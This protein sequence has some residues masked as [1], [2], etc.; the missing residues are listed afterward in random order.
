MKP[1]NPNGVNLTLLKFIGFFTGSVIL[2]VIIAISF[3]SPLSSMSTPEFKKPVTRNVPDVHIAELN[4]VLMTD[5]LLHAKWMQLEEV[6]LT[7]AISISDSSAILSNSQAKEPVV[8][9]EAS[10]KK[11]LDS[12][13]ENSSKSTYKNKIDS[14]VTSFDLALKNRQAL[15]DF[16]SKR[17]QINSH[18][19][20]SKMVQ[21]L[22]DLQNELR[23]KNGMIGKMQKQLELLPPQ[24]SDD[25]ERPH[26]FA[27]NKKMKDEI[28][29]LKWA[30]RSEVSTN[31]KLTD[32]NNQL[33][34]ENTRLGGK[35]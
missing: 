1:L 32:T 16:S 13:G 3:L 33:K 29:F 7:R 11:T 25:E 17:I 27:Q 30:L 10:F 22:Q 14:I 35:E 6:Y 18:E 26:T 5:Q 12:V 9:A 15:N 21:Q 20:D 2:C 23:T 4:Q 34:Q 8:E 19:K 28:E 24:P 31:H